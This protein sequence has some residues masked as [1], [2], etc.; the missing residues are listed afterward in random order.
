M[1]NV[2]VTA[3]GRMPRVE[4]HAGAAQAGG[5]PTAERRNGD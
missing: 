3:T 5:E 4:F 1:V 2:R